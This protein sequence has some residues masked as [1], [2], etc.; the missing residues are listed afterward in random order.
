MKIKNDLSNADVR[1]IDAFQQYK[2]DKHLSERYGVSR[3]TIWRWSEEGNLPKPEKLS[4]G[5][6]RWKLS[7]LLEWEKSKVEG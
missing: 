4:G 2:S 7:D 3:A 6:T 5:C 1:H